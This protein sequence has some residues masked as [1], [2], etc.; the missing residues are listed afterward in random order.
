MK[1]K[2]V[3]AKMQKFF[4]GGP[5][6]NEKFMNSSEKIPRNRILNGVW[7][8]EKIWRKKKVPQSFSFWSTFEIIFKLNKKIQNLT[9]NAILTAFERV[10]DT[11]RSKWFSVWS[12]FW[13]T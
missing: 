8:A 2:I 10:F 3:L 4:E 9:L 7:K 5:E 11:N 13:Q 6:G 12:T 1:K